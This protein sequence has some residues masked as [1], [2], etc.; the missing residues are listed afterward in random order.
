MPGDITVRAII[1][2]FLLIPLF[3]Y[4]QENINCHFYRFH[5][6]N[7]VVPEMTGYA[8]ID[9]ALE[10]TSG[11]T[12]EATLGLDGKNRAVNS[13]TW[14]QL[15]PKGW[16][17]DSTTYAGDFGELLTI[18]NLSGENAKTQT[19]WHKASLVSSDID[20]TRTSIGKCLMN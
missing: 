5:Q 20:T 15:K 17:L 2:V 14:V 3:S 16:E 8:A 4:A 9:Q 7:H 18:N 11:K 10:I 13:T 12:S 1:S 6:T 19:D